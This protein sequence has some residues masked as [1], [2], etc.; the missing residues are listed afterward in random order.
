MLKPTTSG[1]EASIPA[2]VP[3]KPRKNISIITTI[4]SIRLRIP[5]ATITPNS[6][7]RSVI[8]INTVPNMPKNIIKYKI[9][10]NICPLLSSPSICCC[11]TGFI[12][13]QFFTEYSATSNLFAKLDCTANISSVFCILITMD[14]ILLPKLK[15]S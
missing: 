9:P 8:I 1:I 11:K 15:N 13:C 7:L 4:A 3:T 14:V 2:I 5:I 6:R 12:S 10:T